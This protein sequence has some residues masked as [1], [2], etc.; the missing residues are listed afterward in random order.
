MNKKFPRHIL[1]TLITLVFIVSLIGSQAFGQSKMPD[2]G[3]VQFLIDQENYGQVLEALDHSS[4]PT[5]SSSDS[6]SFYRGWALYN[7]KE[8]SR[9]TTAFREVSLSSSLHIRSGLFGSW[10]L[11][12]QKDVKTADLWLSSLHA[13][14]PD[15]MALVKFET[16]GIR[17]LERDL[18]GYEKIRDDVPSTYYAWGKALEK[19]DVYA[20]Q[21]R[22][23]KQ[24]SPALA[25]A[26]SAVVP[27]LGK[28]YTGQTGSGVSAFLICGALGAL[29][30]ENGMRD[31]WSHWSTLVFSGLFALFYA[32]NIYGSM[33]SA[34]E[35]RDY[36][37]EDMDQHILLDMH[38]PL[39]EFY[40]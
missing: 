25:G 32:G 15:E 36:H 5:V 27:G 23:D 17:L 33:I 29:S 10:N 34:K 6:A 28:I 30:V 13:S 39:R 21:I 38:L 16:L 37:H 22:T 3:F 26:L 40:R 31:G 4:T 35:V 20:G 12:Y 11:A 19:L 8:L 9:S 1:Q 14:T 7:L 18:P 2:W 24:K